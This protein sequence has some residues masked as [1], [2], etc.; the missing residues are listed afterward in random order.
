MFLHGHIEN[1]RNPTLQAISASS[2]L[3]Y[4]RARRPPQGLAE[5]MRNAIY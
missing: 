1:K 2:S 4:P 3:L 5:A